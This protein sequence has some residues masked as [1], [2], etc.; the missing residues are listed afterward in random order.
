MAEKV[1]LTADALQEMIQ[2]AVAQAVA[3][4]QPA[5]KAKGGKPGPKVKTEE[6]KAA[7]RAKTDKEAVAAFAKAGFKDIV[8]R[9]D[10]MTYNRWIENGRRVKKGEK[11]VKVGSFPL[12]HISQTDPLVP[13][14]TGTVH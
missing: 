4:A 1:S 14:T 12:F 5:K 6:E 8:P 13:E 7:A 10:V 11:S 3:A 9:V 2:T